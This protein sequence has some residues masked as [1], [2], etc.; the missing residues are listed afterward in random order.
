MERWPKPRE[1]RERADFRREKGGHKAW[2][3]ENPFL[4]LIDFNSDQAQ[5]QKLPVRDQRPQASAQ[6][7]SS[8]D[9][10]PDQTQPSARRNKLA[11]ALGNATRQEPSRVCSSQLVS[12]LWRSS[13]Y[14][15]Q[16]KA[17]KLRS[18]STPIKLSFRRSLSVINV[19][20]LG[21]AC[22]QL[23]PNPR[24]DATVREKKQTRDSPRQRGPI[25]AVPHPFVSAR[26]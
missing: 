12:D 7:A 23:R 20:S 16:N 2:R 8:S 24:P 10:I 14:N 4:F 19:L 22:V 21:S 25:G 13:F 6:L 1:R 11:I 5:L 18:S 15:L 3:K 26:L 17:C 9:Q